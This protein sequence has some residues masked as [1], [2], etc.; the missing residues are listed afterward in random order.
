M[1]GNDRHLQHFLNLKYRNDPKFSDRLN[2]ASSAD[3]D[4]TALG[5]VCSGSSLFAIPFVSF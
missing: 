5:A 4:Q 1:Y 3:P 2:W